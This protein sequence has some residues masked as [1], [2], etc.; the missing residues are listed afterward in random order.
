MDDQEKFY[1]SVYQREISEINEET[2]EDGEGNLIGPKAAAVAVDMAMVMKAQ[3]LEPC[4]FESRHPGGANIVL[5]SNVLRRRISFHID[6]DGKRCEI[7]A[8]NDA[9]TR[10]IPERDAEIMARVKR[11]QDIS[12]KCAGNNRLPCGEDSGGNR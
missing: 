12:S 3:G 1:Q 2:I 7:Y 10:A 4:I 6:A 8:S 11:R 9:G 5:H